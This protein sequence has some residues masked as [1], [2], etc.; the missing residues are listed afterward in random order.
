MTSPSATQANFHNRTRSLILLLFL[1]LL[2]LS[3]CDP[4]VITSWV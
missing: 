4:S 1:S 2:L 3:L